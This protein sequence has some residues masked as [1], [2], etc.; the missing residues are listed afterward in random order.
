MRDIR[1]EVV[2]VSMENNIIRLSPN[3]GLYM[4]DHVIRCCT[5]KGFDE[6]SGC[7]LLDILQPSRFTMIALPTIIVVVLVGISSALCSAEWALSL[8]GWLFLLIDEVVLGFAFED[9]VG[10]WIWGGLWFFFDL[11]I[12]AGSWLI[13]G[14]SCFWPFLSL[15]IFDLFLFT[16]VLDS[17]Y[18]NMFQNQLTY[19]KIAHLGKKQALWRRVTNA[20]QKAW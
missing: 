5:W 18:L 17:A 10:A 20:R 4:V 6:H 8:F 3:N 1:F 13:V 15:T 9:D 12:G 2:G 11:L 7:F 14:W 16:L 19:F